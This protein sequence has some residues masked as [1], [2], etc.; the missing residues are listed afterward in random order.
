MKAIR[1]HE[2]GGTEVLKLEDASMP[3]PAADEILVKIF[4]SGVNPVDAAIRQGGNDV[5][6]PF[7]KLPLILGC[8]AAGIVE[9]I[10]TEVTSFKKGDEVF[11]CPKFPGNGSYAEYVAAKASQF[12]LKPESLSF[13]EAAAVPLTALVAWAGLFEL[14]NLQAG[15]RVLI[16]GASGGVGTFAVQLAK[17]KSASVIATASAGNLEFLRQ[18][19]ADE[20]I[21]Y[22]THQ[23]EDLLH[24]ID[25]VFDASPIR[26]NEHRLKSISVIRDRG[27][28]VSVNVDFPFDEKVAQALAQ[29]HITGEMVA[30]QN[31]EHLAE[32]A[33]LIDEGKVK[34]FVSKVYP[35]AEAAQ[36]QQEVATF[37]VRGKIVLEVQKEK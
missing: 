18:I 14:G 20:V 13:N 24:G 2:F 16:Q 36:A 29:R 7:L 3:V 22:K 28:Y 5:L 32:I 4:A 15:Q 34:V 8:D 26:D 25:L 21:D 37:H 9:A 35:L 17:A 31:H 19:G 11:G 33:A 23:I 12:A 6:R 1:I 10:G 27:T 30:G